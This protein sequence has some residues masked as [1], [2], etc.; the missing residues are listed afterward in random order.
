MD[1]VIVDRRRPKPPHSVSILLPWWYS[2]SFHP[3]GVLRVIGHTQTKGAEHGPIE[4]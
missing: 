3:I 2:T 4:R 1:G